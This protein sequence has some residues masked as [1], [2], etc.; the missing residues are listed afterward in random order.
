MDTIKDKCPVFNKGKACP[1]NVPELKGLGKGCPEFKNGCPFKGV[2]DVGEFKQKLGEM[3]NK[4]SGKENYDKAF[5]VYKFNLIFRDSP[6]SK[7]FIH[8]LAFAIEK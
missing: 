5:E 1:Y 8:F 7:Y 2:K 4:C 3:R 6:P